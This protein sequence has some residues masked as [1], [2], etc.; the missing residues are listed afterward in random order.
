[1]H[2]TQGQAGSS[3]KQPSECRLEL[4]ARVPS[5]STSQDWASE[6]GLATLPYMHL[7]GRKKGDWW[8]FPVKQGALSGLSHCHPTECSMIMSTNKE[9]PGSG[10]FS[11]W[12]SNFFKDPVIQGVTELGP[13]GMK[14]TSRND[15]RSRVWPKQSSGWRRSWKRQTTSGLAAL[16]LSYSPCSLMGREHSP[17]QSVV[18][19]IINYSVMLLWVLK[20]YWKRYLNRHL[21]QMSE[22]ECDFTTGFQNQFPPIG[23]HHFI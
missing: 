16:P 18:S 2:C 10:Y 8:K 1:M 19:V 23:K 20:H 11:H 21:Q 15:D 4:P 12:L 14:R 6:L 7:A 22:V 5:L 9:R 17:G 3:Y 13:S